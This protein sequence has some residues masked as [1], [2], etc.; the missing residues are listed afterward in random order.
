M[1]RYEIRQQNKTCGILSTNVNWK[2]LKEEIQLLHYYDN[3]S[4]KTKVKY[5]IIDTWNNNI[6]YEEK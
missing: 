2:S 1:G 4:P 5:E 6:L 3:K